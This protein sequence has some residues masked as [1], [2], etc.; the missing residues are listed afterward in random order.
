[1]S[2]LH[3][4]NLDCH[5]WF[6]IRTHKQILDL[7]FACKS[8]EIQIFWNADAFTRL[9]P[10]WNMV[11]MIF[12]YHCLIV[13]ECQGSDFSVFSTG[14]IPSFKS[15]LFHP[16]TTL[17]FSLPIHKHGSTFLYI[18]QLFDTYRLSRFVAGV[19]VRHSSTPVV[20]ASGRELSYIL[21]A[22]I[23]M[24]YLV[25]F[26]LVFRPTDILCSIQR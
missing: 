19:W 5:F 1:M 25:T 15:D 6:P 26:A 7:I 10:L 22:G 20:R 13:I 3:R 11:F 16:F 4:Y 18:L 21:L 23:L 12:H 8:F 14:P 9:R 2:H 17:M 24:C